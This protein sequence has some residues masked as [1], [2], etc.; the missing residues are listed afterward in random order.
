[1]RLKWNY[2][3]WGILPK[4][5]IEKKSERWKCTKFTEYCKAILCKK[6]IN[7]NKKE[8]SFKMIH[9]SFND[10]EAINFFKYFFLTGSSVNL[11]IFCRN[12][13]K[14]F[15]N[16]LPATKNSYSNHFWWSSNFSIHAF[17]LLL[18]FINVFLLL[19]LFLLLLFLFIIIS[20][21]SFNSRE[22]ILFFSS[23]LL[24]K[25]VFFFIIIFVHTQFLKR[26]FFPSSFL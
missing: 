17:V 18:L 5:F 13:L 19:L 23:L 15:N 8:F 4:N 7:Y 26:F 2:F 11:K 6:F 14:E 10:Y 12:H 3:S 24:L 9:L 25:V 21:L 16:S 20:H 22:F 1:M